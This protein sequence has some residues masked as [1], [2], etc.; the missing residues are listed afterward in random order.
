MSF[1]FDGNKFTYD[2]IMDVIFNPKTRNAWDKHILEYYI[3]EEL[4]PIMHTYYMALKFPFPFQNRQFI[5]KRAKFQDGDNLYIFYS[6]VPLGVN[7]LNIYIY[8][9]RHI[10][11]V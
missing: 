9:Y 4:S 1:Y 2:D 6:S 10:Q 7:I 5:E 11:I 3:I 8:I